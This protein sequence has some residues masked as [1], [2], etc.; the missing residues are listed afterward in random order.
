[1]YYWY[2]CVCISEQIFKNIR[3]CLQLQRLLEHHKYIR[4]GY[5]PLKNTIPSYH[6]SIQ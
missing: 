3:M 4:G 5:A 2:V 6:D 1:M